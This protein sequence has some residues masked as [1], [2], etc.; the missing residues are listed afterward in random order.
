MTT[1]YDPIGNQQSKQRCPKPILFPTGVL[2][3]QNSNQS[4][5]LR[6]AEILKLGRRMT[7]ATRTPSTI[8]VLGQIH[9]IRDLTFYYSSVPVALYQLPW[10]PYAST[11][12]EAYRLAYG[13]LRSMT[14]LS[15]ERLYFPYFIQNMT[16]LYLYKEDTIL[17]GSCLLDDLNYYAYIS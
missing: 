6:R 14:N 10:I 3:P 13:Y 11:L 17:S 7:Y 9:G 12:Q 15:I 5:A 2:N 4:T 1:C 8:Q 16:V